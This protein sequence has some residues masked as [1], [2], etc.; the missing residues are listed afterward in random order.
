MLNYVAGIGAA[1]LDINGRSI[2]PVVLRDSNP[3]VLSSSAG[4]VTRNILENLSRMGVKTELMSA[5]GHDAFGERIIESCKSAGIGTEH[6]LRIKDHLSST[7]I[8]VLDDSGDMLIGMSDMRILKNIPDKYIEANISL[9]Q[10]AV[11]IVLDG[12][13]MPKTID[14]I[15][16]AAGKTPVFADPVSTA[17]AKTIQQ[18][19]PRLYLVKPN[20]MELEILS[21]M[22]VE[23]DTDI[24]MAA[25]R[26]IDGGTRAVAVSL[27]KRGCYYCDAE[28][29]SMFR[30]LK[31][32]DA[33]QNATGA[34]DAFMA[35]LIKGHM[36]R[37]DK[38]G[39]LDR[40][41]AAGIAATL[42]SSTINPGMSEELINSIIKQ[43]T[44]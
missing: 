6:V 3:G 20:L 43:Y 10:N 24:R 5:I 40:A 33:M 39:M 9:I 23:S 37:L 26:L 16:S 15:L 42:S 8:S 11:A 4:G 28:G 29:T 30:A 27:G 1:N 35:G 18:F 38:A 31:P 25:D 34:G 41:L 12:C 21:G 7:Y 13:L 19:C 14:A 32:V 2:N 17:Y 36:D 44:I 22:S